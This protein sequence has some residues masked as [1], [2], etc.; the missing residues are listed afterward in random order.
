[1]YPHRPEFV[2][3]HKSEMGLYFFGVGRSSVRKYEWA[4]GHLFTGTI[5]TFPVT[6]LEGRSR[7]FLS[8]MDLDRAQRANVGRER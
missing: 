2:C 8:V 1:M 6:Y 5:T 4:D 3:G 7:Q